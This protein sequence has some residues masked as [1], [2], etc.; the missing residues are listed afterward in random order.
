MVAIFTIV[1]SLLALTWVWT[2]PP[3]AACSISVREAIASPDDR[4]VAVIYDERCG[5]SV[6]PDSKV[7]LAGS[8]EEFS[9]SGP[10]PFFVAVLHAA[11]PS[12][13]WHDDGRLI[14]NLS[15]ETRMLTIDQSSHGVDIEYR[16]QPASM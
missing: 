9:Q 14:V 4:R 8:I 3:A 7:A 16:Q 15:Q 1:P 6:T 13:T 10:D 2:R 5:Q 12:V 11:A